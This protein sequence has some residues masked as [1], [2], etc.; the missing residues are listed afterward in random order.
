MAYS[1]R[2]RVGRYR[3]ND[4]EFGANASGN[5]VCGEVLD[6]ITNADHPDWKGDASLGTCKIKPIGSHTSYTSDPEVGYTWV[7]PLTRDVMTLP[8]LGEHVVCI[9]GS[10]MKAQTQPN[11]S[12]FYMIGVVTIYGEKNENTM[13][14]TGFSSKKGMNDV[15][16]DTFK[17][18]EVMQVHPFEGDTIVQGRWDNSLRFS[19]SAMGRKTAD[20]WSIG[21]D[22]GD[23]ITILTNGYADETTKIEDINKDNCSLMMTSTQKIDIQLANKEAPMMVAVPTGPILP[24]MPLNTYMKKP[25]MI[26]QSDRLVFNAKGDHVFIAA[27]KNI[28][29]STDKWKIDVSSLADILLELINQLTMEVHPTPCGPT[30]PPINAT[31]YSMLKTQLESMKQ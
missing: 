30:G 21:S 23:P 16:G 4:N 7:T 17:E 18:K 19:C 15:P 22:N 14:N 28:S 11:S 2:N 12:K 1:T 9:R 29:L 27:K 25:Q 6:V 3:S 26:L 5:I 20:T 31:I 24:H 13:Y 10:S 8:V